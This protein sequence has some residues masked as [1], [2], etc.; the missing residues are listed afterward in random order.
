MAY[1]AR[2]AAPA[3]GAAAPALGPGEGAGARGM[4]LSGVGALGSLVQFITRQRQSRA[5]KNRASTGNGSTSTSGDGSSNPELL[6]QIQRLQQALGDVDDQLAAAEAVADGC[7]SSLSD[8][9]SQRDSVAELWRAAQQAQEDLERTAADL[10]DDVARIEGLLGLCNTDVVAGAAREGLL[11]AAVAS[12]AIVRDDLQRALA[13]AED[14]VNEAFAL[15]DGAEDRVAAAEARVEAATAERVRVGAELDASRASLAHERRPS[16][17]FARA[18]A[19]GVGVAF[20]GSSA[21]A[22]ERDPDMNYNSFSVTGHLWQ[23]GGA[24]YIYSNTDASGNRRFHSLYSRTF[25]SKR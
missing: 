8:V 6:E 19:S 7:A 1:E 23:D 16:A 3:R 25:G 11:E 9:V 18:S 10:V 2:S 17:V 21:V 13:S 24:G 4:R 20:D 12:A 15:R 22:A 14:D 5:A